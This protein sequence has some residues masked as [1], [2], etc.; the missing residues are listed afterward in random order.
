MNKDR[1]GF[2]KNQQYRQVILKK[3]QKDSNH[4]VISRAAPIQNLGYDNYEPQDVYVPEEDSNSTETDPSSNLVHVPSIYD[5]STN[6]INNRGNITF[7]K[8]G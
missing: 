3:T 1:L 7:K 2:T 6:N 5:A 4:A 8:R